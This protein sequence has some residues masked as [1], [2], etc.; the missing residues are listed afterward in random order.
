MNTKE[1]ELFKNLVGFKNTDRERTKE[2][3]RENATP[4]VLGQ[5]FY[6][7]MQ[8]VA[9]TTLKENDLLSETTREFRNS[10]EAAH[11]QNAIKYSS[12]VNCVERVSDILKDHKDKYAMLKGAVLCGLYPVGC[13]T[14]N[15]I[16]LLVRPKDITVI[17]DMLRKAGFR[18]G[19]IKN[20]EFMPATRK[21]IITSKMM[22][23][24]TIPYILEVN[25]PYMQFLEVDI[26]F[27]LDY[28]NG[29][30]K[31]VDKLLARAGEVEVQGV[32]IMT[33]SDYD[34]FMHLCV[35][36]Y[37]EATTLPWIEMKRDMTLYKFC[38]IYMLT[39]MFTESEIDSLFFEARCLGLTDICA[40][41][42]IA[43][44]ELFNLQN[45]YAVR[46]AYEVLEGN[47]EILHRVISPSDKKT[48]VYVNED[49]G[50]RF[51]SNDRAGM[52]LEVEK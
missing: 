31:T 34:F 7:R 29:G 21:E 3:L 46:C 15:D 49:I 23:G 38:D 24:E 9:Y 12:F 11:I 25:L 6:N 10:L 42:I 2:L 35:H 48:F 32:R 14:S 8:G 45:K 19:S 39:D 16:D 36:L 41:A 26:N 27:S 52:L 22:R 18:Q 20:G 50:D 40:Y 51:F 47:E 30:E 44:G 5:L 17:G 43:A 37:K 28:K 33:L 1:R 13:R 4:G